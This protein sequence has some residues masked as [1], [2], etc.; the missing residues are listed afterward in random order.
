[1]FVKEKY[2]R[3]KVASR[4]L[5]FL[6]QTLADLGVRKVRIPTGPHNYAAQATYKAVGYVVDDDLV[7]YKNLKE[8]E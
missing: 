5:A 8:Q 1:M 4:L 2:R 6:E 3:H 7:M